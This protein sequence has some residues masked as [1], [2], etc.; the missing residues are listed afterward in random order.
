[1]KNTNFFKRNW[2][3]FCLYPVVIFVMI[4]LALT[5]FNYLLVPPQN[6]TIIE[7]IMSEVKKQKNNI[8]VAFAGSSRTYNAVDSVSL[9]EDFDKNIFN[10]AYESSDFFS[11]YHL[12]EEVEKTN[13]LEQIFLEVSIVNFYRE[14]STQVTYLYRTLTGKTKQQYEKGKNINYNKF[15]PLDFVNYLKNFSNGRFVENIRL[16]AIKNKELGYSIKNKYTTYK[17]KGFLTTTRA[18][19]NS[20]KLD[21][22]KS[23]LK[24]SE[25]WNDSYANTLQVKYFYKIIDWCKDKNIEVI[26]YSPP[27]PHVISEKYAGD[28]DRFDSYLNSI[29][30]EMDLEYIDFSKLLKSKMELTN[31]CFYNSNHLNQTGSNKLYPII[32]DVYQDLLNDTYNPAN[33]FYDSYQSMV[34]NY[35]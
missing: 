22:P 25:L 13:N 5:L 9:S 29:I 27:Y 17:G 26:L 11:T 24:N 34:Q 15:K 30:S 10:I 19:K 1:M 32:K 6:A 7:T 21:L 3:Y 14:N 18:V 2:K 20:S 35:N 28:F 23:Y 12:L 16:K 33:Y 31:D 8:D 4:A